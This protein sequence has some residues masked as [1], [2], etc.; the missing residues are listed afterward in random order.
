MGGSELLD[1]SSTSNRKDCNML[2]IVGKFLDSIYETSKSCNDFCVYEFQK[3]WYQN[4]G[5]IVIFENGHHKVFI[6]E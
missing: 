3:K 4:N 1:I 2:E 5:Y 6:K